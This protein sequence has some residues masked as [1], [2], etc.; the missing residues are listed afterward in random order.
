MYLFIEWFTVNEG[1][2]VSWGT[3]KLMSWNENNFACIHYYFVVT[4][5][6]TSCL[7]SFI[8]VQLP[9]PKTAF[10]TRWLMKL[11]SYL[12]LL[13]HCTN[14]KDPDTFHS[15]HWFPPSRHGSRGIMLYAPFQT[16][17]LACW[18]DNASPAPVCG[19]RGHTVRAVN[20]AGERALRT[21]PPGC[22]KVQT[23]AHRTEVSPGETC[24]CPEKVH[25]LNGARN[26]L[27][28]KIKH[29]ESLKPPSVGL[30]L[31]IARGLSGREALL[32]CFYCGQNLA[33]PNGPEARLQWTW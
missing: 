9:L 3:F 21:E 26:V 11:T 7:Q 33:P 16:P 5:Q 8:L 22:E 20:T 17:L 18:G 4:N 31:L 12:V 10:N 24:Q 6:Y 2:E 14:S 15:F 25:W 1:S 28:V 30:A 32:R 27:L 23:A 19:Q 29:A 13:L